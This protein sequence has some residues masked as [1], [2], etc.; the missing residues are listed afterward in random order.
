MASGSVGLYDWSKGKWEPETRKCQ[1][2]LD[3]W[4]AE[5]LAHMH[6]GAKG[7]GEGVRVKERERERERESQRAR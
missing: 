3:M 6:E 5:I 7:G 1:N 4:G 2:W